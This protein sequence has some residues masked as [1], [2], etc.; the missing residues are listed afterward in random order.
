MASNFINMHSGR[1]PL[2][3]T[4]TQKV[5]IIP[6]NTFYI[7]EYEHTHDT[8]AN[9]WLLLLLQL[10]QDMIKVKHEMDQIQIVLCRCSMMKEREPNQIPLMALLCD[11]HV[12]RIMSDRWIAEVKSIQRADTHNPRPLSFLTSYN[13]RKCRLS[14]KDRCCWSGLAWQQRMDF[15]EQ[16]PTVGTLNRW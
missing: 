12:F 8:R 16:Q 5:N 2:N 6:F 14:L 7:S 1:P 15:S 13:Y 4:G 9:K 3:N 10:L 11:C